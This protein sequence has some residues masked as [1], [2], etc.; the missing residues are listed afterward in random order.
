MKIVKLSGLLRSLEEQRLSVVKDAEPGGIDKSE[1]DVLLVQEGFH[2]FKGGLFLAKFRADILMEKYLMAP[3]EQLLSFPRY[4]AVFVLKGVE[5]NEEYSRPFGASAGVRG[6]LGSHSVHAGDDEGV[7]KEI[8]TQ[9]FLE[10]FSHELDCVWPLH[11]LR[12]TD[13]SQIG[14]TGAIFQI[15]HFV[16]QPLILS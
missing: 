2:F 1:P 9:D 7:R 3:E 10:K 15:L 5:E 6:R 12:D 4:Y 14:P 8:F 13:D 11:M 16:F